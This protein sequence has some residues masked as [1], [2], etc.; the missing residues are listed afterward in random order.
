[1]APDRWAHAFGA[2]RMS[3]TVAGRNLLTID[4]YSGVDPEVNAFG[5]DNFFTS[6]FETQP[7]VRVWSVRMNVNF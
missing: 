2:E 3:M 5:Q 1:M 6:D 4:D 7:P